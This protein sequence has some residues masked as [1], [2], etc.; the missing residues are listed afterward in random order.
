MKCF[1]IWTKRFWR[2]MKTA[3]LRVQCNILKKNLFFARNLIFKQCRTRNKNLWTEFAKLHSLASEEFFEQDFTQL[4][5]SY[6][7]YCFHS[8]GE[9]FG[10][11]AKKWQ[12]CQNNVLRLRWNMLM[13]KW[14]TWKSFEVFI[15]FGLW[16]KNTQEVC[17][18]CILGVQSNILK[19]NLIFWSEIF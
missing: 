8:L 18:I 19:I 14:F 6:F 17:Q 12:G 13:K 3:F 7:C 1:R 2:E 16:A 11:F 5:V 4:E 9:N 10:T 15:N